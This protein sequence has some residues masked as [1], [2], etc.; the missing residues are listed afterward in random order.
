M[1]GLFVFFA[2]I[3][4]LVG[5]AVW[6]P[7][8]NWDISLARIFNIE[9]PQR[10]SGLQVF[11]LSGQI[12]VY[13]DN[14]FQGTVDV[15]DNAPLIVAP[16]EPGEHRVRLERNSDNSNAYWSF[17]RLLPFEEGSDVIVSFNI[18]PTETFSAGHVIY[19]QNNE[20][21][22]RGGQIPVSFNLNT[23]GATIELD[24]VP[25]ETVSRSFETFVRLD[26]QHEIRVEKDGFEPLEFT[27]LPEEEDLRDALSDFE[28]VIEVSLIA[29]PVNVE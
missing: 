29:Q 17:R 14:E 2:F 23:S 25:F 7:W 22:I 26:R 19:A 24:G 1:R 3:V 18:G 27:L 20:G 4:F 16:I 28:L 21:E 15:S 10:I 9:E 13:L 12:D 5:L 11:S 6:S 8:L